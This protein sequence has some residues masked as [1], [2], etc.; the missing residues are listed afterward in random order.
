MTT[1][2]MPVPDQIL[3]M[4]RAVLLQIGEVLDAR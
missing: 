3:E 1:K 4:G 2:S